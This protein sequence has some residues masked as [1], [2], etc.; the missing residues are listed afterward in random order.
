MVLC[1]LLIFLSGS[2]TTTV[3][4]FREF[5]AF[6]PIGSILLGAIA[7]TIEGRKR[8]ETIR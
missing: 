8:G 2:L 5:E 7:A 4:H 6:L 1:G 3:I